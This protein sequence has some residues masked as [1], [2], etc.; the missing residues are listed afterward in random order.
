MFN[1]ARIFARNCGFFRNLHFSQ[2]ELPE[3]RPQSLVAQA[4][5]DKPLQ[6]AKACSRVAPR[7]YESYSQVEDSQTKSNSLSV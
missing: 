6:T 2:I 1:P 3:Q 5:K 4:K 7:I